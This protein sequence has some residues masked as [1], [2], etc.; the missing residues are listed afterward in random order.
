MADEMVA[1]GWPLGPRIFT[2]LLSAALSDEESGFALALQVIFSG[3][4]NR[5]LVECGVGPKRT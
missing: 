1:D 2:Y 3:H 5:I 4:L